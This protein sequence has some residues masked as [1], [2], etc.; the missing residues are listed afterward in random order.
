[1]EDGV[2]LGISSNISS[3]I[4][5]ARDKEQHIKFTYEN[6][7]RDH[8]Y[9]EFSTT[10]KTKTIFDKNFEMPLVDMDEE[11]LQIPD[12]EYTAEFSLNSSVFASLI[13]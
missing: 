8:L 1:M 10:N 12:I 4:L 7:N 5:N 3:K 2:V 6:S 13:K 11:T 9:I